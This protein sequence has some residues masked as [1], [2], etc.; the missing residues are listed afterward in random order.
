MFVVPSTSSCPFTMTT[1]PV[2][3]R[4]TAPGEML[5]TTLLWIVIVP[6]MRFVP[7]QVVSAVTRAGTRF[8]VARA[9]KAVKRH[10][11]ASSNRE[12]MSYG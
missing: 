2:F 8:V 4:M 5:T 6:W 7:V 11:Q 3:I 1:A 9:A 12:G 10:A